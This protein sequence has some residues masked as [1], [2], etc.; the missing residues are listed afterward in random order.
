MVRPDEAPSEYWGHW[1]ILWVV[2]GLLLLGFFVFL[3]YTA[4]A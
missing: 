1:A 3:T 2:L 4:Q